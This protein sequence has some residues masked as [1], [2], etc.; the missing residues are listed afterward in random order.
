MRESAPE[1]TP[2]TVR[3]AKVSGVLRPDSG[4]FSRAQCS[5]LMIAMV[6]VRRH[7]A[8]MNRARAGSERRMRLGTR[9]RV[10]DHRRRHGHRT[11]AVGIERTARVGR[12][13]D[14]DTTRVWR[15]HRRPT[16]TTGKHE[17]QT[18]R[19]YQLL[20]RNSVIKRGI[21]PKPSPV[22]LPKLRCTCKP[23]AESKTNLKLTGIMPVFNRS[24]FTVI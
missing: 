24:N 1:R 19:Q 13:D 18:G 9:N 14:H 7:I 20:H 2:E 16:S 8:M 17:C 11:D 6:L 3:S 5:V 10:D 4:D 21:Q 12:I 15:S 22:E 23:L